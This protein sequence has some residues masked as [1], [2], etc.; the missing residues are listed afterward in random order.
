MS[1]QIN[2]FV[3]AMDCDYIEQAAVAYDAMSEAAKA[4][5]LAAIP[6]AQAA[7]FKDFAASRA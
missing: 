3:Q 4:A 6:Q 2:E 7:Y 5:A 1:K